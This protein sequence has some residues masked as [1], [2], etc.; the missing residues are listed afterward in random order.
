V[1]FVFP[2]APRIPV[3]VNAGMVMPAWYDIA[4]LDFDRRADGE[5]VERS[6]DQLRA[7]IE[8]EEERG[9]PPERIVLAGFSQGG[10]IALHVALHHPQRLAGVVA[11]STYLAL[12]VE[13]LAPAN[14]ELPVFQAHGSLDPMVTMDK[15]EAARDCMRGLGLRVDWHEYSMAHQVC[16]EEITALGAWLGQRLG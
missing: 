9:V 10:A 2:H 7:L 11:L 3:T 8:R 15:G 14:A 12:P 1:R 13:Q 16:P 4:G 6:A 5:G